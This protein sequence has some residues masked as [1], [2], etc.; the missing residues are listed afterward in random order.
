MRAELSAAVTGATLSVGV[1]FIS[2]HGWWILPGSF[3]V[4]WVTALVKR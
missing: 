1:L 4:G 2:Y 3:L